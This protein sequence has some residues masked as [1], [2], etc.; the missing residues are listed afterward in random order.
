LSHYSRGVK[1]TSFCV[2]H[3][4]EK[5]SRGPQFKEKNGFAILKQNYAMQHNTLP[6]FK[7]S[8]I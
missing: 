8:S 6:Y 3:F 5:F 2:P 4:E 7:N 1:L